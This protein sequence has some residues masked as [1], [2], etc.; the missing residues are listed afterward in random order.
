M[1]R[2]RLILIGLLLLQVAAVVLYPPD[3]FRRAPQSIVLPPA[4]LILFALALLGMNVGVLTPAAG[5][6]SLNFVQGVNI[7]TR[8]M[9]LFA[10]LRASSGGWDGA[11]IVATLLGIAFSWIAILLMEKRHPRFLLLRQASSE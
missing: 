8:L 5:R 11:M 6:V 1:R 2:E 3:F 7:V 4:F 9:I 10:N